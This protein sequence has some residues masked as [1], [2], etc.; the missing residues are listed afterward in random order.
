MP[1]SLQLQRATL[2][3]PLGALWVVTDREQCVR[4]VDW[5]GY[6]ERML[7]LL[8]RHY[9]SQSYVLDDAEAPAA[10]AAAFRAYFAGDLRALDPLPVATNGTAFQRAVWAALRTIPVGTTMSYGEF[11]QRIGQPRAIRAVG[12]ANGS[13]PIGVIVPCHRV[14]G[15]DGSL[16]G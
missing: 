9:A 14:I 6:E 16:T 5:E 4:A 13:N 1:K 3:T 7:R 2:S 11:A 10:I 8:E 12:L 15:A